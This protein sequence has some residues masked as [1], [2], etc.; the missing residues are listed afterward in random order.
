MATSFNC[1]LLTDWHPLSGEPAPD[2]VP[3]AWDGPH[4]GKRLIEAL[5]VLRRLPMA[6]GP[7]VL[8][9]SWPLYSPDYADRAQ[10]E[11][12][13]AWK[14]EQ[15]AEKNRIRLLPIAVEIAHMEEA[16]VWPARYLTA[17][18]QLLHAVQAVALGRSCHRE[19][20][21][22]ARRLKLPE[23]LVRRWNRDGL[24]MV[25]AGLRRDLV[26]VF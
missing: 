5:R 10:Y 16:I 8:G 11:D 25:A 20:D 6:R 4:V 22:I 18:P 14:A 26:P 23:R 2:Y 13:P 24:D 21:H 17:L 3:S 1:D 12:D 19:I 9:N 7:R 15:A